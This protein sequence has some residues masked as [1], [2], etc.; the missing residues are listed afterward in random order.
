MDGR[1][2]RFVTVKGGFVMARPRINDHAM[3][4]AER[5]ARYRAR[6]KAEAEKFI[7]SDEYFTPEK[8]IALVRQVMGGID[9]DPASCEFAQRTVKANRYFTK[10]DDGL[11]RIWHGKVWLNPPYSRELMDRFVDKICT[12]YLAG[13]VTEAVVLSL[14]RT[15]TRWF[16]QLAS[17]STCFCLTNGRIRFNTKDGP[18][19]GS[20]RSGHT[21]FYFGD[22]PDRF[23]EIFKP[24]GN[25]VSH[26]A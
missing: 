6:V 11:S 13:S 17:F 5:A 2:R 24:L 18:T 25:V 26:T 12:E 7:Q 22:N 20:G 23:R 19:K 1:G 21:F 16:N 9:L 14:N 10:D 3:T 4:G 15:D 8:Y